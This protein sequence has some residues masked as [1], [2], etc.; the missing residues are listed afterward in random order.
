MLY[1]L[2]ALMTSNSGAYPKLLK[3]TVLIN[4]HATS[5]QSAA[6]SHRRRLADF[7]PGSNSGDT[8]L[9]R[10]LLGPLSAGPRYVRFLG[11]LKR[12][13]PLDTS[14]AAMA[15]LIWTLP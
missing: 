11:R 9:S 15:R 8:P 6:L 13:A 5:A 14:C 12:S 7:R 2:S 4:S 1:S 3:R 10:P